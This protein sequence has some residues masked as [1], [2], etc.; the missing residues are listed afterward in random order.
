[1]LK[2]GVQSA[3]WYDH[4]KALESFEYIKSCGFEAVDYN[5]DHYLNPGK[6]AKEGLQPTFFDQPVEVEL[7]EYEK[8]IIVREWLALA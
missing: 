3:G 6:L 4:S 7:H 2:I 5:I 1:M 8:T